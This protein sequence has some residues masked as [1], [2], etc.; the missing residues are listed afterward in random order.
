MLVFATVQVPSVLPRVVVIPSEKKEDTTVILL[1]EI[2]ERNIAQAFPWIRCG[3]CPS[4]PYYAK[5]G[6]FH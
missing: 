4:L 5:C 3:L 1:E 6:S 2:I